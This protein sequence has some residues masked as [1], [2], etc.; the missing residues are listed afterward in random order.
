MA[1][2]IYLLKHTLRLRNKDQIDMK[3]SYPI[4]SEFV[5]FTDQT[6]RCKS[7]N[8]S[9]NREDTLPQAIMEFQPFCLQNIIFL[10]L[11][12]ATGMI[13]VAFIIVTVKMFCH[14]RLYVSTH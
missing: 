7:R 2:C 1:R 12:E 9:R 4:R 3:R 14:K 11:S 6:F 13:F 8:L 5:G 10:F